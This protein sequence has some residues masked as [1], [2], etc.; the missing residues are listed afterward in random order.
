MF[1]PDEPKKFFVRIKT[2]GTPCDEFPANSDGNINI[3]IDLSAKSAAPPAG[4][5]IRIDGATFADVLA[6]HGIC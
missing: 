6:R 4:D 5:V 1:S 3:L 2:D